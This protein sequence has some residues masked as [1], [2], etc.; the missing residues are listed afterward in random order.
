[1]RQQENMLIIFTVMPVVL[2]IFGV[3]LADFLDEYTIFKE[4]YPVNKPVYIFIKLRK[5]NKRLGLN[6][7]LRYI[8][9]HNITYGYIVRTE[10][11][12]VF[13]YRE[14]PTQRKIMHFPLSD[15]NEQEEKNEILL[16]SEKNSYKWIS[17]LKKLH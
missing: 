4:K 10:D 6:E 1:M 5:L 16:V 14:Y 13:F 12:L 8:L 9:E 15:G 3:F 17:V 7:G 2:L 11:N